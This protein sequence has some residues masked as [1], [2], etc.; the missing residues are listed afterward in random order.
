MRPHAWDVEC[1]M[2]VTGEQISGAVDAY[3]ALLTES[4]G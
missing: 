1:A 3:M 2:L 4:F